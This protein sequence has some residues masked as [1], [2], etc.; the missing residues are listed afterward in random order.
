MSDKQTIT[1]AAELTALQALRDFIGAACA[2][3]GIADATSYDLKLAADEV[4]TNI[5][6]HGYAGMN[7][8]SIMLELEL[9]RA[10]VV[11]TIT[12]FGHPFEPYEPDAPDAAALLAGEA[13]SG[14][15]LF[16]I[17]STMDHVDYQTNEEGNHTILTKN[18]E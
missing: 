8:G 16:F 9:S 13:T 3:A 6:T 17:Y 15:G 18:L 5:I 11:M 2:R 4:C 12:D 7:P 10:R 1:R 14:F